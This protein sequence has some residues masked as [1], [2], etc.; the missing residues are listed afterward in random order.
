MGK[1]FEFDNSP[2]TGKQMDNH[3]MK[4]CSASLILREMQMNGFMKYEFTLIR[5]AT[6]RKTITSLKT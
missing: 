2:Q 3:H 1:G 4:E 5:R 6:I